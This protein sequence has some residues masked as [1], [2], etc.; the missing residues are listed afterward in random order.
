MANVQGLTT[1]QCLLLTTYYLPLTTHH[2]LLP[3]TLKLRRA[4][5]RA[6]RSSHFLIDLYSSHFIYSFNLYLSHLCSTGILLTNYHSPCTVIASVAKRSPHPF[7][8][9]KIVIARRPILLADEATSSKLA[10]SFLTELLAMNL[11]QNI[12]R[13]V[14]CRQAGRRRARRVVLF[15]LRSSLLR[16]GFGGQSI[17]RSSF[18]VLHSTL[19]FS[20][21]R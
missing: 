6:K 7:L 10:S 13:A 8:I 12:S 17:L 15:I 3:P 20:L 5:R 2:S 1:T 19:H 11:M 16:Q 14:P 9:I 4:S 18:F 21:L